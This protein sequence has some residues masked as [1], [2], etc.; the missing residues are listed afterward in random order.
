MGVSSFTLDTTQEQVKATTT[1]RSGKVVDK[2]ISLEV[3][4]LKESEKTKREDEGDDHVEPSIG[5]VPSEPPGCLK[6]LFHHQR[7]M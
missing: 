6:G 7:P 2:T 5:D 3:Q 1:L 4:E